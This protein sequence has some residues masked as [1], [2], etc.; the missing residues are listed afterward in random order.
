MVRA[1]DVL[2]FYVSGSGGGLFASDRT[3]DMLDALV[4][5]ELA[6]RGLDIVDLTI[7]NND[8]MLSTSYRYTADVQVK[9]RGAFA[10]AADVGSIVRSVFWD[11]TG[12]APSL[13]SGTPL[14]APATPEN[15]LGDIKWIA[16]AAAAV[17]VGVVVLKVV[18]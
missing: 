4:R 18:D 8:T 16:L 9:T 15:P 7:E 11:M 1:G 10:Q 17:V 5:D 3:P 6:A 12:S 2:R 14:A 13:A